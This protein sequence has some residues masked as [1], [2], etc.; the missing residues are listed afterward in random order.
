MEFN[1]KIRTCLGFVGD[2]HE[3]ADFYVSSPPDS[4]IE[5]A[6]QPDPEALRWEPNS[7]WAARAT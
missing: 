4:R 2:G 6:V 1:A 7:P 3:A 5:T